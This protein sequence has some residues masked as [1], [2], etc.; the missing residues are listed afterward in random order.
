MAAWDTTD[1]MHDRLRAALARVPSVSVALLFGSRAR[2]RARPDSDIDIAILPAPEGLSTVD[3]DQLA[4][5]LER[6]AGLPVDL[7]RLD[8]AAP[9]LRWRV[10]RDGVV[11]YSHPPH[12]A[13]RFLAREAIAH[14]ADR[15]LR[16]EAMRRFRARVALTR[17]ASS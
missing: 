2:G 3:E 11:L 17:G 9:S 12:A 5:E 6:A 8:S 10:A 14:D 4:L 16:E 13:S 15:E 1:R 7:V